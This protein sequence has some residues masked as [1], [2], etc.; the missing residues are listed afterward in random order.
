MNGGCKR[1]DFVKKL[2]Y[3]DESSKRVICVLKL[4]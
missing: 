2:F 3:V 1:E 4:L